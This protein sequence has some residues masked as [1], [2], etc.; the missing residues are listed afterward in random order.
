MITPM[1]KV[2]VL[3]LSSRKEETLKAL[4]EMEII[5]LTPLQN[6][7][8][9]SVNGAKSAVARVQKAME[10]VPDK[11]RKGVTPATKGASGVTLVEEIQTLISDK[12]NAE[13]QLEQAKEELE[14]LGAFGNLDPR[15]VKELAAKGIIVRLYLAD[16]SKEPFEVE[17]KGAYKHVFCKNENGTYVAVINKGDTPAKVKGSFTEIAM[18]LKSLRIPTDRR[19]IEYDDFCS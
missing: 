10:V 5:H 13:I 15:T 3:T 17:D 8:G 2:T 19:G 12:K 18:P 14:K 9:V 16:V 6:A 1:K 11:L 7:A 4:R